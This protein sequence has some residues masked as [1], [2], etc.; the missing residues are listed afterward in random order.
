MWFILFIF[1]CFRTNSAFYEHTCVLQYNGAKCWG[2]NMYGELGYGDTQNRGD[3]TNEMG[4]DLLVIDLGWNFTPIQITLGYRHTCA[5]STNNTVK[6]WGY[7]FYGQLG[8][9]DMKT[10][11]S[12][13]N[14]MGDNLLEINLGSD[15]LAKQIVAGSE[16]T[17]ALSTKNSVKC[18]GFNL[19]GQLGY[20]DIYD[21]RGDVSNEMADNLLEIDLGSNF[22]PVQIAASVGIV[23]YDHTCALS[24]MYKVKCFGYN[25]HGEL[26]YGDTN[27]RGGTSNTMGDDLPEIDLGFNF[28]AMQIVTGSHHTCA[29]S[30]NNRVKCWG[31]NLYGQLGYG[32]IN[33]RGYAANQMGDNLLDIG[34]GSNFIPKQLTAGSHHTC[35]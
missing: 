17:C 3:E 22:T 31:F 23:G 30:T 26:G 5:L 1:S 6:C 33:N 4:D 25:Y 18:W 32:D 8:Y 28:T 29:L 12:E 19:Y 11:G 21:N 14:Q 2:L 34:L 27:N 24:A 20:S 13:P 35:A 16:H 9:G 15:F 10:R 7:N